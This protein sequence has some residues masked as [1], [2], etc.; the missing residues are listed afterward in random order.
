MN[1]NAASE[2]REL[3]NMLVLLVA[4]YK[5]AATLYEIC[6]LHM[7]PVRT[8]EAPLRQSRC[9]R[10]MIPT[11][12]IFILEEI[13]EYSGQR[14]VKESTQSYIMYDFK[15]KFESNNELLALFICI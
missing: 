9:D 11:E 10:C 15:F 3:G 4:R 5:Q 12:L 2:S 13:P 6:N 7:A 1:Q 8:D 14:E